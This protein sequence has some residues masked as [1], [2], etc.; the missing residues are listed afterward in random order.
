MSSYAKLRRKQLEIG[1]IVDWHFGKMLS[2]I[3]RKLKAKQTF[4]DPFKFK[5]TESISYYIFVHIYIAIKSFEGETT[6]LSNIYS[7][8]ADKPGR[9]ATETTSC[10]LK[11][12]NFCS[13]LPCLH[14]S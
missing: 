7:T 13:I 11:F 6:P 2:S 3:K 1:P 9:K 5:V 10:Y 8:V 14:T 12:V 4:R